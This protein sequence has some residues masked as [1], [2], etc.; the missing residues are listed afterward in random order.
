MLANY[1][2]HTFRC[3]HATG[4]EREYIEEAIGHYRILG[5]SDHTPYPF[6][7]GF[8]DKDKMRMDQLEDYVDT[9]LRLKEEYKDDIELH[10]GLE[11][12]YYPA[13]FDE[14]VRFVSDYPIEYFILG[15]HWL[16]NRI[17][18][19]SPYEET[20]DEKRI[21]A[22][23]EQVIE[24][25]KTRR[26]TYLAHPDLI[27]FTG[28]PAVYDHW[29]RKLCRTAK[30]LDIPLEIN[31]LGIWDHRK[32]PNPAFWP[33]AAQEG[34]KVVIGADAHRKDKVWNPSALKEAMKIVE[35]DHLNLLETIELV[36]PF[37][38]RL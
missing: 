34:C 26:F 15:Q 22:Y 2:T 32:Y 14:L 38:I 21:Q 17:G 37:D 28:D 27:N 1:H 9:I 6:P 8:Y 7:D 20:K 18:E 19:H 11:V 25:L 5:F 3:N 4:T 23:T 30:K 24:G 31:L 12:E 33:I 36:N 16:G 35:E 10:V 29:M 13:Y